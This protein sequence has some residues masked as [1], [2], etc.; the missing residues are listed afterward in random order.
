MTKHIN[1]SYLRLLWLQKNPELDNFFY[2]ICT[3]YN[4]KT[5]IN[6]KIP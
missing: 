6:G 4:I 3:M 1:K 2:I 5:E